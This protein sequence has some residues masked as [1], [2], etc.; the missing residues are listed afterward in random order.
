MLGALLTLAFSFGVGCAVW[1]LWPRL[2]EGADPAEALGLCGLAGLGLSGVITL[3][4][5]LL[6]SGLRAAPFL[7]AVAAAFGLTFAIKEVWNFLRPSKPDSWRL[8]CLAALAF[9][10][11]IALV[12]AVGPS[13]MNDWDSIAYHLAVPKIWLADGRISYIPYIHH[14]NFPGAIDN[15]FILGLWWG[16]AAG[17]KAFGVAVFILGMLAVFGLARRRFGENAA[18]IAVIAFAGMPSVLWESGTAYIDVG[19]GLFAGLGILYAAEVLEGK[20]TAW[21]MALCLALA[22]AT[23]YTGLQTFVAVSATLAMFGLSGLRGEAGNR[24][25]LR[26][27]GLA[28]LA[29]ALIAG[30]WYVRNV[31]NT[32]NPVYPFFY[33]VFGGENWDAFRAAVYTEEQKTFG[34]GASP[35]DLGAAILGPAYQP[36]RYTNPN[37]TEGGG[38]PTGALGF[39]AVGTWLAWLLSGRLGR[40]ER[41]VL[42]ATGISLLMWFILSQ[43]SRYL[44]TLGIPA[45]VLA[46]AALERL[47]VGPLLAGLAAVQALFALY[48]GKV[49]HL[50]PKLPVVL[51]RISEEE[52][53]KLAAPFAIS[54]KAINEQ[55]TASGKV[56]LYDE[57]FGYYLD[58]PY[59]WANP[60]H[61]TLIPYERTEDG[62]QLAD[63]LKRLG[64]THVYVNFGVGV[65]FANRDAR[66]KWMAQARLIEPA[67]PISAEERSEAFKD[68]RTKWRMLLAEASAG[69]RLEPLPSP[70]IPTGL[71]FR[72]N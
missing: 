32:G 7:L 43:Q 40:L 45:A 57:V 68:L 65:A 23:K 27:F 42:A 28:A 21:R 56:A 47:R 31:V 5:G 13:D 49:F 35:K 4:V 16:G 71:L 39:L 64:F 20:P 26:A 29:T 62:A 36:G 51:G 53:L 46:G 34:A 25:S 38:M 12:G 72:L 22:C 60:G 41:A 54:A 66:E 63:E 52:Y 67:Q 33:G 14:S 10:V 3:L 1:R 44:I 37:P 6:P 19:H 11:L 2:R 69:G 9:A 8:A 58:V 61:S 30:P 24:H 59:F 15:L 50:D 70:E 48:V 17:A 55:V 18:W